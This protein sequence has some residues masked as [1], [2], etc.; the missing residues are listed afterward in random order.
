MQVSGSLSATSS[1]QLAE[2]LLALWRRILRGSSRELYVLLAELDLSI[3]QMKVLHTLAELDAT[4]HV[5]ELGSEIGLSL[6]GASRAV[7]S[8]L[9]R[10]L[11]ERQEDP[12]DRRCKRVGITPAGREVVERI[13]G[14]RLA[15]MEDFTSSLTQDQRDR[16][17]A[18]L[19]DL[20]L[21]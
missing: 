7:D 15:G 17:S 20:S 14:A 1:T 13:D 9:R 16:L 19:S 2:Q 3:T 12:D 10:G 8:L 18:A 21:S 5:K 4:V 11:L 6:P